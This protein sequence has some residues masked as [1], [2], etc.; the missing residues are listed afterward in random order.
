MICFFALLQSKTQKA[1]EQIY[2]NL[3]TLRKNICLKTVLTDFEIANFNAL[4]SIF[5][6]NQIVL[7]CFFHLVQSLWRKANKMG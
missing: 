3:K 2:N 7:F 5:G 4:K 1:Y 6:K